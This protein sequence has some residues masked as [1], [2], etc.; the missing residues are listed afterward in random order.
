MNQSDYHRIVEELES[1]IVD[2]RK[3]MSQFED[4]SMHEAMPDDYA[5]LELIITQALKK[6]RHYTQEMLNNFDKH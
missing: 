6:Q 1:L 4:K 2:T 5:K 3:L